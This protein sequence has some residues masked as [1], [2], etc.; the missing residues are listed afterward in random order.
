MSDPE[1]LEL[2]DDFRGDDLRLCEAIEALLSLDL[3]G[4]LVPCGLGGKGSHAHK[5][6]AAA[7]VRLRREHDKRLNRYVAERVRRGMWG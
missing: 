1:R 4:A 5:L 7:A 2:S 3:A 6:L